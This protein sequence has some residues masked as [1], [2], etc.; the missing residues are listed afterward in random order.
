MSAR[1]VLA[2]DLDAATLARARALGLGAAP[3]AAGAAPLELARR[4][5]KLAIAWRARGSPGPV[6]V[7]F[8]AW[9]ARAPLQGLRR[10]LLARALGSSCRTVVDATAGLG[11]D[12][13]VL[14][15][16]GGEVLAIERDPA[17][18]LLLED[19]LARAAADPRT[20][21]VAAR[22]TPRLGDARDLLPA[23]TPD[24]VYVD[25]MFGEPGSAQVKKELQALRLLLADGA[26]SAGDLLAAARAAARDRVIVKR[27]RK[28]PPLGGPPSFTVRGTRVR[29]DVY[30]RT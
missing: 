26:Q 3:A 23:L 8:A 14:A 17:L 9:L 18:F 30:R 20:R 13:L 16:C 7:D 24:A 6:A 21:A 29:F 28:A 11:R 27:A 22:I 5:G 12:A 4:D 2:A 25:P 19:G 10:Q 1:L 15:A